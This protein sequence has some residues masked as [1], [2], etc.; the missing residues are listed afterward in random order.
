[1][2]ERWPYCQVNMLSHALLHLLP[3]ILRYS[4]SPPLL[5]FLY[6]TYSWVGPFLV[7]FLNFT[8]Y[9]L[10]GL[11]SCPCRAVWQRQRFSKKSVIIREMNYAWIKR[12]EAKKSKEDLTSINWSPL[13]SMQT[14]FIRPHT[15]KANA[16]THTHTPLIH[17]IVIAEDTCAAYKTVG[18]FL[19]HFATTQ[20][21]SYMSG[22]ITNISPLQKFSI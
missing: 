16:H 22:F 1:M 3:H 21:T 17:H 14:Q 15:T 7:L 5:L 8:I 11:L 12:S 19:W 10:I 2:T 4:P 13:T 20:R 18:E 6:H 9:A